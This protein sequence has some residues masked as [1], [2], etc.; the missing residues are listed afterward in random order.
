VC[1]AAGGAEEGVRRVRG[2][3]NYLIQDALSLAFAGA[4]PACRP[5]PIRRPGNSAD[6]IR[7]R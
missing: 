1:R 2:L 5:R 3:D 7:K 6:I 4:A